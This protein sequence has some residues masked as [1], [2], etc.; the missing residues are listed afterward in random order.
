MRSIRH[1]V[2]PRT[3]EQ[4]M[5]S[6]TAVCDC[7]EVTNRVHATPQE[8]GIKGRKARWVPHFVD[9]RMKVSLVLLPILVV[10]LV[11]LVLWI[12][13]PD[14]FSVAAAKATIASLGTP[15][16]GSGLTS[17]VTTDWPGSGPGTAFITAGSV[18]SLP[19]SRTVG[20]VVHD[21]QVW[22]TDHDL[23]QM[24]DVPYCSDLSR[25][26]YAARPPGASGLVCVLGGRIPDFFQRVTVSIMFGGSGARGVSQAPGDSWTRYENSVV[27]HVVIDLTLRQELPMP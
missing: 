13:K 3:T 24:D 25:Q 20:E 4:S 15:V 22:A 23:G 27:S 14:P 11:L 21:V 5:D 17:Q 19:R 16:R 10:A 8:E 18:Y 1:S 7:V 2:R 9:S 26:G 6:S 12:R